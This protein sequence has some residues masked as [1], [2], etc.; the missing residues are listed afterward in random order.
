MSPRPSVSRSIKTW[1]AKCGCRTQV[2]QIPRVMAAVAWPTPNMGFPDNDIIIFVAFVED[3]SFVSS[4][5]YFENRV[6]YFCAKP[7]EVDPINLNFCMTNKCFNSTQIYKCR[8][9]M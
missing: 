3:N 8:W 1:S 7:K 6:R 4:I 9:N 2:A 5:P